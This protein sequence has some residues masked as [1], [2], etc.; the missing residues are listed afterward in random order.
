MSKCVG[1]VI[2]LGFPPWYFHLSG[3]P[4]PEDQS[5]AYELGAVCFHGD[6]CLDA[7]TEC[8]ATVGPSKPSRGGGYFGVSACGCSC[9]HDYGYM[10]LALETAGGQCWRLQN[11]Y[12][13]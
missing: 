8:A 9:Y 3:G 6:A 5:H 11:D 1:W 12:H 10:R 13:Q 7:S 2:M 4:I